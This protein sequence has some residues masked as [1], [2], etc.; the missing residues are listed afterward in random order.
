MKLSHVTGFSLSFLF[1]WSL[2][3]LARG[4]MGTVWVEGVTSG[5]ITIDWLEPS[6]S[7]RLD[8]GAHEA[9]VSWQ[10]VNLYPEDMDEGQALPDDRYPRSTG[11]NS[12]FIHLEQD[13]PFTIS[14]LRSSASYR[15]KVE[16]LAEKRLRDGAWVNPI[17][18]EVAMIKQ[19]TLTATP[20]RNL[21]VAKAG[22][23][24]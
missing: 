19:R 8:Q 23:D 1:A 10:L 6:G 7:H 9:V 3:E 11:G 5:S 2:P 20:T 18:R 12:R 21:R 16:V 4:D 15:I 14:G 24:F 13:K 17:Y 22:K